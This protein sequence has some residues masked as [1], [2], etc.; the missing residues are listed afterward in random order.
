MGLYVEGPSVSRQKVGGGGASQ[1]ISGSFD[2]GDAPNGTFTVSLF[3]EVT[4]KTYKT[5]T[6]TLSRPPAAPSGVEAR[7]KAGQKGGQKDGKAEVVVSWAKGTEPDLRS[8]EISTSGEA[9]AFPVDAVC[10]GSA[11][12]AALAAPAKVAGH[13][14]GF[15]VRAV[16]PD[17][18][19]GTVASPG[20][21][22]HVKI[23][24][25]AEPT[26]TVT[27]RPRAKTGG[28]VAPGP[29]VPWALTAFPKVPKTELR[30]PKVAGGSGH[31]SPEVAP[32]KTQAADPVAESSA[33]GGLNYGI[34]IAVA[35]ALLLLGIH[36][37]TWWMRRRTD[38][39]EAPTSGPVPATPVPSRPATASVRRPVVI[40]T[41]R[42]PQA[43]K[44]PQG[45]KPAPDLDGPSPRQ[46]AHDV[47]EEDTRL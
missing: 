6:F 40:L 34:L 41:R 24:A 13:E 28:S 14:V 27:A 30:L 1:T 3:G 8:Y 21:A 33:L 31:A 17:G 9:S 25:V 46:P 38:A 45:V 10:S 29:S 39:D 32:A 19:G 18:R 44:P 22:A 4:Q 15:S 5:S 7:L 20:S 47:Y 42:P 43:V 26:P 2:P 23:P 11:C 37:G 36:T 12:R 16:R 35:V